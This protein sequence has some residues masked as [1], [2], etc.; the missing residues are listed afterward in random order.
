MLVP[1]PPRV[2]LSFLFQGSR[3]LSIPCLTLTICHCQ[4]AVWPGRVDGTL[5][6]TGCALPLHCRPSGR[7]GV[8][9][10][11]TPPTTYSH[12]SFEASRAL[13]LQR[14]AL[15]RYAARPR[16]ACTSPLAADRR[17]PCTR[18]HCEPTRAQH[19]SPPSNHLCNGLH[20]WYVPSKVPASRAQVLY[21]GVVEA[22]TLAV[23]AFRKSGMLSA[24]PYLCSLTRSTPANDRIFT[25]PWAPS[26]SPVKL[27]TQQQKL[28]THA[29]A[30][31]PSSPHCLCSPYDDG[32]KRGAFVSHHDA[33]TSF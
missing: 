3:P 20:L 11:L 8:R 26:S 15:R 32:A 30:S 22:I 33:R 9:L 23:Q 21:D 12:H 25:P 16:A 17:Q 2:R 14:R 4:C 24:M 18:A 6:R 1:R 7:G 27:L 10:P 13:S 28:P 29:R 19:G 5:G 31:A